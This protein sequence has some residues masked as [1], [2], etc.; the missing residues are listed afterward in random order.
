M[1]SRQHKHL[2]NQLTRELSEDRLTVEELS[3]R[4]KVTKRSVYRYFQELE[5][6]EVPIEQGFDKRYF[7]VE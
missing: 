6:N 5:D 7:I 4:L 1:R 3:D 2:I